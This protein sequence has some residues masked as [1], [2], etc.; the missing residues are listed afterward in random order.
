[1]EQIT[2][3]S[4]NKDLTI[5]QLLQIKD[6]DP[7]IQGSFK[8]EVSFKDVIIMG[9]SPDTGLFVPTT[10]PQ[11]STEEIDSLNGKPFSDCAY[12]LFRKF[13]T[14]EEISDRDLRDLVDDAYTFDYPLLK[15]D[16][17]INLIMH[18]ESPTGDFKNTGARA[19]ARFLSKLREEGEYFIRATSTS[20]DTGGAVG[21]A[22]AGVDGLL[23]IILYPKGHVSDV[24]EEIMLKIGQ[25]TRVVGINDAMFSDIQDNLVKRLFSDPEVKKELGKLNVKL[26]SGNSI[27]WGRVMPQIIHFLYSYANLA[28]DPNEICIFS[29]PQGNMGHGLSGEILRK[30]GVPIYSVCPT[31]ENDP[32]PRY[33]QSGIYRPLTDNEQNTKCMSNSMIVK[34]PSNLARLFNFYGGIVDKD[35]NV[36]RYPDIEEMK[37]YIYS[38]KVT[39][40]E[41]DETIKRVYKDSGIIIDPHGACAIK[42]LWDALDM[43]DVDPHDVLCI[44]Q[45][46]AN[47]YKYVDHIE[48]LIGVRPEKPKAY[49]WLDGR[50]RV[51]ITMDFDYDTFKNIVID[52]ARRMVK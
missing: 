45:V 6:I 16:D 47:P 19:N 36:H 22:D 1:M 11:I 38:S 29:T 48:S 21:L 52:E 14:P 10:F 32:F 17:G 8:E 42:G 41:E 27:N 30:M 13:I 23:S 25:N 7:N 24:Q 40:H 34:N 51:G 43:F 37:K 33:L 28:E 15:M 9:Q 3:V 31:N 46:T 26:T 12:L 35:G 50:E 49:Q 44:A 39:M 18:T 5:E 2:Y 4:T 20:G